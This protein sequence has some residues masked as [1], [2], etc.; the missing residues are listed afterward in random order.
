MQSK[1]TKKTKKL[2]TLSLLFS[3]CALLLKIDL[4]NAE[5]NMSG[6]IIDLFWITVAGSVVV[7]GF[8]FILMIY[9]IYKYRENTKSVRNRVKDETK[10]EKAWLGFA[11]LLVVILV[12]ISTPVLYSIEYP[13]TTQ[14]AITIDVQAQRFSWTIAIPSQNI[15]TYCG[16]VLNATT[17]KS[18]NMQTTN[19]ANPNLLK[20]GPTDHITLKT[21]QQYLLNISS[22]DVDHSFFA[23]DLAIKVDAI[24]GQ[25]NMRY[26]SILNAGTYVV[27]C[28]EFCGVN[29]YQMQF[30]IIAVN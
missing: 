17:Q 27:T 23:Y 28:A 5:S 15:T 12:V 29:H 11:I 10:F 14:G 24:P 30:D 7:G 26:F 20:I 8:V 6:P 4:G 19:P 13:A 2:L 9:F 22:V 18:C 21:H 16:N 25:F 3:F 1:L